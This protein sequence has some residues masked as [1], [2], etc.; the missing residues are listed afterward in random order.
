MQRREPTIRELLATAKTAGW[1]VRY[2]G[3]HIVVYPAGGGRPI[4]VPHR[5]KRAAIRDQTKAARLAGLDI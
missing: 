3:K 1:E 5:I 2:G 4:V